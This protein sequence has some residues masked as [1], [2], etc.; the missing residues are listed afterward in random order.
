MILPVVSILDSVRQFNALDKKAANIG[1]FT[2]SCIAS[3]LYNYFSGEHGEPVSSKDFLPF[4]GLDEDPNKV[5]RRTAELFVELLD[6]ER[7]P[8]KVLMACY[9]FVPTFKS[10]GLD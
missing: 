2:N 10:Y 5:T 1:S 3:A 7:I 4:S 8:E 6:A 9:K